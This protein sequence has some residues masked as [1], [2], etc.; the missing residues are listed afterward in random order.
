MNVTCCDVLSVEHLFCLLVTATTSWWSDICLHS[1]WLG[2][3]IL[4]WGHKLQTSLHG[5]AHLRGEGC[6][7]AMSTG[8]EP[9]ALLAYSWARTFAMFV[10]VLDEIWHF[11]LHQIVTFRFGSW[12]YPAASSGGEPTFG[13]GTLPSPVAI[14]SEEEIIM[15]SISQFI[16]ED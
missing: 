3:V 12:F 5:D 4:T 8:H 6:T 15:V 11:F 16:N 9:W 10:Q 7:S 13:P 14:I 1:H 2:S